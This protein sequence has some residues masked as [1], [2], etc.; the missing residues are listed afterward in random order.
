MLSDDEITGLARLFYSEFPASPFGHGEHDRPVLVKGKA[1]IKRPH[2]DHDP[3]TVKAPAT[4]EHWERHLRGERG[5]GLIPNDAD[6]RT[7]WGMIDNDA[8]ML[9]PD[10][11]PRD[12]AE[13]YHKVDPRLVVIA[14]KSPR[15]VHV[16]VRC[17]TAIP[18]AEMRGH[19]RRI[20]TASGIPFNESELYPTTDSSTPDKPGNFI[21]MLAFG[22][23]LE[24]RE[25]HHQQFAYTPDGRLQSLEATLKA[26]EGAAI[27]PDELAAIGAAGGVPATTAATPAPATPTRVT[28]LM[29]TRALYELDRRAAE[30][31]ATTTN[32]NNALAAHAFAMGPW[33]RMGSIDRATVETRLT[34]AARAAGLND[35]EI[36]GVVPR[37]ISEGMVKGDLPRSP[38][39]INVSSRGT[40]RKT[41]ANAILAIRS[42]ELACRHDV[43]RNRDTVAGEVLRDSSI[44]GIDM[45]SLVLRRMIGERFHIDFAT[46]TVRDAIKLICR[47]NC[48]DPVVDY[49]MG[50]R[51]DGRPRLG[52]MLIDY[53]G[54]EDDPH[55]LNSAV[56]TLM[57]VAAVRRARQPGAKFD[58]VVV[59]E[60]VQGS[61]KSTAIRILAGDGFY[62]DMSILAADARQQMELMRGIWFYELAEMADKQ[63][64]DLDKLK[65]FLS[66]QSDKARMAY[67]AEAEE[68]QRRCIFIGTTNS[69]QY[70]RDPTGNRRF[71]PVKTGRIDLEALRRDRDQLFA[72]AVRLEETFGALALP[73]ELYDAAGWQQEARMA[74]DPWADTI[75]Q[76]LR[77]TSYEGQLR[78]PT[79][80]IYTAILEVP[81]ERQTQAGSKRIADLMRRM[82]WHGPQL[83]RFASGTTA[84]GYWRE[85]D[86]SWPVTGDT[87]P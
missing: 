87:R 45:V 5:L 65:S 62:T 27:A 20:A 30:M 4:V 68:D 8:K 28:S 7:T 56:S 47:E 69:G 63:K 61:G 64:A 31:A 32:R 44:T 26:I 1:E 40:P 29:R 11:T 54:A 77:P 48:F 53:F 3:R 67:G 58:I 75:R 15:S 85:D 33:I 6:G 22:A 50:L 60:G 18:A 52:R 12:V 81:A 84:R 83:L 16:L 70:L 42:F 74:E 78:V 82:G 23:A 21:N 13:A 9:D 51:W 73:E 41:L 55:G 86:G 14:S 36:G 49:L 71:L 43:F 66:R 59:L 39:W 10:T 25:H 46:D 79:A 2:V 37:Q 24:S 19:M 80:H 72:E 35:E 57:M 34:E 38:D 76:W 17:T